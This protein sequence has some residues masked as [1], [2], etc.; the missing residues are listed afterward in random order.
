MSC[1]KKRSYDTAFKLK[2]VQYTEENTNRDAGTCPCE[3]HDICLISTCVRS[4]AIRDAVAFHAKA[5]ERVFKPMRL[6]SSKE[7][8]ATLE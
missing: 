1:S 5:N 7:I 2:V 4:V 3:C 6:Q 8:N